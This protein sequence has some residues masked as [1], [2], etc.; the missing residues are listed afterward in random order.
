MVE[1]RR[2]HH[3]MIAEVLSALD[4]KFLARADCF[5]GGGTQIA[6]AYGEFRESRDID[7]LCGSRVG[8]RMLRETVNDRSLGA[9]FRRQLPLAREVRADRDGVR[10]FI[11]AGDV[12]IKLEIVLEA[13]IDLAG[14]LDTAL[15]VPVLDVTSRIAEKLLANTD[16][17]LDRATRSR[18]LIDLAFVAAHHTLEELRAGLLVAETAYGAAVRRELSSVLQRLSAERVY[19]TDCVRSLGIEDIATMRR[20]LARLRRLATTR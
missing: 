2:E 16:R 19:A 17:G 3:R 6:L 20:G 1:F 11:E 10:T 4:G 15:G 12:R 7:L 13:R 9:V 18:D 14:E 8:F 5:F